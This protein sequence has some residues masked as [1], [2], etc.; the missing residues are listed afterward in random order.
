MNTVI[1]MAVHGAPPND[2]PRE[3]L[4]EFFTLHGRLEASGVSHSP[5]LESRYE[6]LETK[7]KNWPRTP[8]N[9]PYHAASYE[10]A[11]KLF[12]ETGLEVL[13]GFNEFC[14]PGIE[15]VLAGA[16][17]GGA[18]R[19]IVITTMLT[20]GG[21]HAERDINQAVSRVRQ[22]YPGVE[23]IYAWPYEPGEIARFLAGH[24]KRYLKP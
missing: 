7:L 5:A 19:V 22:R 1:V 17:D 2:F 9:D 13:V 14:A 3:E 11:G 24:L 12:G 16:V 23:I 8:Q 15:K 6:E 21:E 20:R 10:L 4:R 18:G